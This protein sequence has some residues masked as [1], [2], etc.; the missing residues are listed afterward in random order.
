MGGPEAGSRPVV[1]H[2]VRFSSRA[3]REFRKLPHEVQARLRPH[4]D[5]L[6][7]NPRPVGYKKLVDEPNAYRIRVGD[8]RVIYEIHDTVLLV[9]VVRVAHRREAY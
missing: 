8:Y 9:V 1:S 6:A 5:V 4:I 2:V 3:A 7:E